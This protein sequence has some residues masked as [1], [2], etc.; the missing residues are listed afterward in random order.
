VPTCM[1]RRCREEREG[2]SKIFALVFSHDIL[3]CQQRTS[4]SKKLPLPKPVAE[5]KS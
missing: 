3:R 5:K 4:V 2:K 1:V